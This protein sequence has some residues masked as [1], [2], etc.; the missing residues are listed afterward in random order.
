[1]LTE[2]KQ[3][4]DFGAR[5]SLFPGKDTSESLLFF[6]MVAV[7]LVARIIVELDASKHQ[8]I[9]EITMHKSP[10]ASQEFISYMEECGFKVNVVD[11]L[12]GEVVKVSPSTD[13]NPIQP[14]DRI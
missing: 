5:V 3:R 12:A 13:L 11:H 9:R 4:I 8:I 7:G 6:D 2:G 10:Y 1:M 14:P